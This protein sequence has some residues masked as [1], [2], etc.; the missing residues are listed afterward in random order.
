MKYLKTASTWALRPSSSNPGYYQ[1]SIATPEDLAKLT[2]IFPEMERAEWLKRQV[3]E[4][5]TSDTIKIDGYKDSETVWAGWI[6]W[7]DKRGGVEVYIRREWIGADEPSMLRFTITPR[8]G[9]TS[10]MVDKPITGRRTIHNLN[11]RAEIAWAF[12]RYLDSL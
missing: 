1:I 9:G 10:W 2:K 11:V 12:K 7:E 8:S 3:L 5:P 6:T 4:G